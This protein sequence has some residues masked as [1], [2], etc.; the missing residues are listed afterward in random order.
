MGELCHDKHTKSNSFPDAKPVKI[1]PGKSSTRHLH[2][3][4]G[5][6]EVL[7]P[8]MKLPLRTAFAICLF[9]VCAGTPCRAQTVTNLWR[10]ELA[11][12]DSDSSP[13]LAPDGTIYQATF[14][15]KLVAITPQ[16]KIKWTFK[17]PLEIKS[18]PAIA[19]DGTIYF[20]TRDRKLYAVAPDGKLKWAFATGGWIDSSPAIGADGTIYFGSWDGSFYALNPDGS[21]KWKFPTGGIIDSSPAIGADGTI[22][23]G[24]HDKNFYALSPDG[25]L[26]WEFQTQGQI[27]SSPAINSDGEI[28]FTSTDGNLYALRADGAERWRLHTDSANE[29][30][31]MLDESGDLYVSVK[32]CLFSFTSEGIKRGLTCAALDNDE[33]VAIAA[34]GLVYFPK[35]WQK[36]AALKQ[37]GTEQWVAVTLANICSSPAVGSDG[38][39]YVW[40]GRNLYAINSTSGL[41]PLAKSPWPMW[42]ANAQH[43]GRVQIMK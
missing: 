14:N 36:L 12:Y 20:G 16:G 5:E 3:Q 25:K 6:F 29:S 1:E 39:I 35:A 7:I 21:Q 23:F 18:S 37:D 26:R 8:Q 32:E 4:S 38:T 30:S 19:D 13:A 40:D 24:S 34:D 15:G 43:T 27:I 33:T 42:R 2:L 28:Y 41:A 17:T 9:C 22:Y 11:N 31:P 10:L